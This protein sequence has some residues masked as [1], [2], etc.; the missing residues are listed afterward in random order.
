MQQAR[1]EKKREKRNS[2]NDRKTVFALGITWG[3]IER[4]WVGVMKRDRVREGV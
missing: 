4:E 3:K 2:M 1:W